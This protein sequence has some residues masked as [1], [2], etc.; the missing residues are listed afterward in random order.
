MEGLAEE[1]AAEFAEGLAEELAEEFA[2]DCRAPICKLGSHW[3]SRR[4]LSDPPE[5]RSEA[6]PNALLS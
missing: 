5:G 3:T 6:E 4:A 2:E 1:F